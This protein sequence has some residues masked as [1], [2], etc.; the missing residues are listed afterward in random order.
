MTKEENSRDRS[1]EFLG[2]IISSESAKPDNE[3]NFDL[4]DECE[5][6]LYDLV[7]DEISLSDEEINERIKKVNRIRRVKSQRRKTGIGISRRVFAAV[8]AAV[9][10]CIGVGAVCMIDPKIRDGIRTALG[11]DVGES[12]EIDGITFI[13][14]GTSKLYRDIDEF[15]ADNDLDIMY[16]HELP[17]GLK[18]TEVCM[19]EENSFPIHLVFEDYRY[20]VNVYKRGDSHVE[21]MKASADTTTEVNGRTFFVLNVDDRWIALVSDDL[22]TYEICSANEADL[23]VLMEGLK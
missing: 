16:P 22:Y 9:I 21:E 11:L 12:I 15:L 14:G 18:I 20:S 1:I 3:A 13:N 4:I 8:C 7:D 10:L 23:Y 6:L 5:K 19:T 2:N 17:N